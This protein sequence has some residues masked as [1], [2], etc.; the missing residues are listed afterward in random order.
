MCNY[1]FNVDNNNIMSVSALKNKFNKKY[2]LQETKKINNINKD[3]NNNKDNN[4]KENLLNN[5]NNYVGKLDYYG[6]ELLIYKN[7]D[8]N[9]VNIYNNYEWINNINNVDYFYKV[10]SVPVLLPLIEKDFLKLINM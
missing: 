3:N 9:N 8:L 5:N 1:N 2:V 6:L 4:D 10:L 7:V